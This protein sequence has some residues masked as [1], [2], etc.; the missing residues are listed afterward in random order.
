M[1]DPLMLD[2]ALEG[3]LRLP[4][5]VH[6]GEGVRTR[7][8][9]VVAARGTRVLLVADPFLEGTD[10]LTELVDGLVARDV[11]VQLH[12]DVAPE[13]PVAGLAEAGRA[14]RELGIDVVV[15]VGGG[16]ALDAAKCIALLARHGG[17]L[18]RFYGEHAVPGPTVPVVALPTTA[19]T[20]SEVTPV[21]VV[22]DPER[23]LKVGIS[24]PFLVPEVALVDPDLVAGAPPSVVAFAGIDALA[25]A[26]ESFTTRRPPAAAVTPVATGRNA[27]SDPMAL[28]AAGHLG[29]WLSRAVASP[30][31]RLAR[32]HTVLGSLAAGIAFGS[33]GVHLGHALQ[34]PIGS[35]TRTPHGLGTG[36]L[37]PYVMETI[38]ADPA[39]AARLARL[40]AELEP[41]A[42]A[43][44]SVERT[45]HRVAEINRS[46]GVPARLSEI[47]VGR[48]Q[49]PDLVAL[50][51]GASRL[52]AVA[53]VEASPELLRDLVERA[54]AGILTGRP[55][56]G[57]PV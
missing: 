50:A 42:D 29:P 19:G 22:S 44:A 8:P 26:V 13:L 34:Y 41:G 37:L 21:A 51:S 46:I 7:L 38:A 27:L 15:A 25:H 30:H 3:M 57:R 48:D 43:D 10:A 9:E 5:E 6:V 47:G 35:L 39:T 17:P 55:T 4:R 36:L 24:S 16:S 28:Q 49:I 23:S 40:G 32:R 18:S 45:V 2:A 14:A 11:E 56:P 1:A 20:G 31:D 33:T 52:L 12:T 54:H 53:P